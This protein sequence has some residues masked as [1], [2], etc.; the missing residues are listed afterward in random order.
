LRNQLSGEA[1]QRP[2]DIP[3]TLAGTVLMSIMN[4][5]HSTYTEISRE[6]LQ[7]SSKVMDMYDSALE[8]LRELQS[9]AD[10]EH[11]DIIL[12]FTS[13]LDYIPAAWACIF[14]G[15][16]FLPW[17]YKQVSTKNNGN[18]KKLQNLKK[19]LRQPVLVT[20]EEI[21][22]QIT[23]KDHSNSEN[24][25]CTDKI[26]VV[27][28]VVS[29]NRRVEM[30]M[31]LKNVKES[32][33]LFPTS[34]TTAG[35]KI[36]IIKLRNQLNRLTSKILRQKKRLAISMFPFDSVSSSEILVP[37]EHNSYFL[38]LERFAAQPLELLTVIEKFKIQAFSISSSFAARL[39]EAIEN[40]HRKFNLESLQSVAYGAESIN[41]DIVRKVALSLKEM[42]A[43]ELKVT[44]G[45]GM[46]E[47]GLICCT[48]EHSLEDLARLYSDGNT[49]TDVGNCTAGVSLR[50]VDKGNRPLAEG[51]AG[52]IQVLT[53]N[54][55]FSGYLNEPELSS[56]SF[57]DDGWFITGD[58]GFIENSGLKITGRQKSTIIVNARNISLDDI[59]LSLKKIA[60]IRHG[61]ITAVVINKGKGEIEELALF[62]VPQTN[63][64]DGLCRNLAR[65]TANAKGISVKHLVPVDIT[66]FPLTRTGKINRDKLV[67]IYQSGVW[68]NHKLNATD[69]SVINNNFSDNQMWLAELWKKTLKLDSIPSLDDNFFDLGGDSLASAELVFSIEEKFLYELNIDALFESPSI[70]AMAK[71]LASPGDEV[72]PMQSVQ[73]VNESLLL[74]KLKS[75]TKSWQGERLFSDGMVVGLNTS[76]YKLPIFWVFQSE[77]EFSQLAASMGPDQPVYGM[78]S[79]LGIIK[80]DDYSPES[81]EPICDL[82]LQE[83]LELIDKTPFILGGN[84]QGAI[85][86]LQ[87]AR[88]LREKG[89]APE[90]LTLLEWNFSYGDYDSPTLLIYGKQSY[91]AEIYQQPK[92]SHINWQ[93][94]FPA[95]TVAEIPGEHGSFFYNET[96][97]NLSNV[98]APYSNTRFPDMSY[99]N[100]LQYYFRTRK[101]QSWFSTIFR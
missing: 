23:D 21:R 98:L 51:M 91:T 25:I 60:G 63:D 29:Q 90:L 96:V 15:Y 62:F 74:R 6:G 37:T 40:S 7:N 69:S 56:A 81:L 24:I 10:K 31:N 88:R 45:Y 70:E 76:G 53:S 16:N 59:E 80:L 27:H 4:Y 50:I 22:K 94:D 61:L 18:Q 47:T 46:T 35:P 64:I 95:N 17:D 12:C 44:F 83:I 92:K 66:D 101:P 19:Q 73:R 28:D 8:I 42:G 87:L 68:K 39:L 1:Y 41:Q 86:A 32:S 52:N 26:C 43:R 11:V 67:D 79:C 14:G 89:C 84:C 82:Y 36:V 20:V 34:G 99:F 100:K 55:I 38:Q 65:E 48:K 33:I 57:T 58:M 97:G 3:D 54:K 49:Q 93:I 5:P 71:L 77:M 9:K 30:A 13:V 85:I 72:L 78:R 75:F 2:A